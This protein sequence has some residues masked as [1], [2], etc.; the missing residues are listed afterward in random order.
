MDPSEEGMPRTLSLLVGVLCEV[1]LQRVTGQRMEL[2]LQLTLGGFILL[3]CSFSIYV[4]RRLKL[5]T[6]NHKHGRKAIIYG[7][8]Y[9]SAG[10]TQPIYPGSQRQFNTF[11]LLLP[12]DRPWLWSMRVSIETAAKHIILYM[13]LYKVCC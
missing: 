9:G 8:V 1:L 13:R 5:K 12:I 4:E 11:P 10:S 6:V 2:G 7:Y 3:K